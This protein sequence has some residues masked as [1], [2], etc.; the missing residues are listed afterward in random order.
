MKNLKNI[1]QSKLD[2]VG[3]GGSCM[4]EQGMQSIFSI[5]E[6]NLI[7]FFEIIP[8][9]FRLRK[10]IQQ[11]VND[12][13]N[14]RPDLLITID[15]PGFTYRVVK[16]IRNENP[17]LK[18]MHIVAPSVWA[19]K[20]SRAE[21][22]AKIYDYLLTLLPF[23]PPY[24]QKFGLKTSYIGHP[25]LEQKFYHDKE[26]LK[27]ELLISENTTVIVVTPGSRKSEIIMH[28]PIFCESLNII[29]QQ[30]RDIEVIFVLLNDN[31]KD[32]IKSFLINTKFNFSFSYDRLKSY[33]VADVA[34]AKS[35]TNTLE[36]AASKTPMIVT[37]KLNIM[38][39][40][41]IKI[42]IR[43]KY[44]S[45]I[46]IIAREEIIPEYIQPK[47]TAKNIS[48]AIINLLRNHNES[49][50]QLEKCEQ[51]LHQLGFQSDQNPSF[52]AAQI[53]KKEFLYKECS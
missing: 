26:Q 3:V 30:Y 27:K 16:K 25:I 6:I 12:I 33:G 21:K 38:S 37:Y 7:G 48:L 44:I 51:A 13:N 31:Y 50:T 24:F 28:M 32:L 47:C 49:Q 53:I 1:Y 15:S 8:H 40:F 5:S 17:N 29:A 4:E 34:I 9:I 20:P 41:F 11:T 42:F 45:L 46:N 22:Y 10:L 36:I 14:E 18:I 2:F 52:I 43:I 19:Y 23:E 39:Y 35:G